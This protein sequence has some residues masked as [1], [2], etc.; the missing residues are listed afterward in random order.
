MR[1]LGGSFSHAFTRLFVDL[2]SWSN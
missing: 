1:A 2:L